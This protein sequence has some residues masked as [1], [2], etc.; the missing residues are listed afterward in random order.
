MQNN[1]NPYN[2][3]TFFAKFSQTDLYQTLSKDFDTVVFSKLWNPQIPTARHIFSAFPILKTKFSAVPFYYLSWLL[4][5]NPKEIYD[6]G[7]G[8]NIFKKYIPTVIGI[9]GE[10]P[11]SELFF[12]DIHDFVDD[13]FIQGHQEF[14][15]SVF[16]ICAL[17]F[18]PLSQLRQRILDFYSMIAPNGR[19][20]LSL[21]LQ[22]MIEHETSKIQNFTLVQL[23]EY[24]R[25]EIY[26]TSIDFLVVDID[27][28]VIDE[29]MNGNIRLV[30][31]K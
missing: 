19:G 7:C 10:P 4:E 12:A 8:C 13:G 9:G 18:I 25:T 29:S 16:S 23:E 27:F 31:S 14:F 21:N 28:D 22:R 26:N 2:E 17:H 20:W 1:I 11:D 6:L 30:M 3:Q 5:Q 24:I 15:E